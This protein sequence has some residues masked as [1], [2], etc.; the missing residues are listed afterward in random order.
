MENGQIKHVTIIGVGL[1]GG[2]AGLAIKAW[3]PEIH[4]AGVGRRAVSLQVALEAGAI[5]SMHLD[6][7]E[8]ASR[9]DLVVLATPVGTFETYLK[10][11]A[12]G[13]ADGAIVT[14]VGSTKADVVAQGEAILGVG[15]PFVGS[16][17]MAGSEQRGPQWAR[18]DLFE[19]ATC[20]ITPTE[21]TPPALAD[22]VEAFWKHLRMHTVRMAPSDHDRAT[23]RVSH[24]PHALACLLMDLPEEDDLAVAATGFRDATRLASGDPEMWRDIFTTNGPA[25]VEAIG[26][27]AEGL[28][29]FRRIVQ[30][31]DGEQLQAFLARVKTRRDQTVARP[32]TERRVAFE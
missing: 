29:T 16:H 6:V 30:A 28:Q 4:V 24:L 32:L 20:I 27:L 17:P 23:A 15:G 19:Q 1:L 13:L 5:D 8:P 31:G 18:G 22:T 12:D 3:D 21:H 26:M 2:S 10:Q 9:T 7:T 11:L 25:V 14:D